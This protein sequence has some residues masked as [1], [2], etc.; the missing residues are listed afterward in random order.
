MLP[1]SWPPAT[2]R[3][4]RLRAT[5]ATGLPLARSEAPSCRWV[6]ASHNLTVP[7]WLPDAMTRAS[8]MLAALVAWRR[9]SHPFQPVGGTTPRTGSPPEPSA[10]CRPQLLRQPTNATSASKLSDRALWVCQGLSQNPRSGDLPIL[11]NL[12]EP[13]MPVSAHDTDRLSRQPSGRA[14]T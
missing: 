7:S 14:K 12:A 5:L 13:D 8:A 6:A 9:P 2:V 11:S 1:S 10:Y 3:R 4:S